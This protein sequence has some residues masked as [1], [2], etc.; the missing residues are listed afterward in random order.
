M[1]VHLGADHAAFEVK[2]ALAET[3]RAAGHDVVDHGP[4]SYDAMDDYPVFCLRAA[5]AVAADATGDAS[6]GSEVNGSESR[7]IVL[8][9]SGN[10]EQI[11]AN[12]VRGIRAALAWSSETARLAREHNDANVVGIGARMHSEDEVVEIVTT[13]LQTPYS[14]EDRHDRRIGMITDYETTGRLP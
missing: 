7:G 2:N 4:F 8:G 11:V 5:T 1:R 14:A 3:L 6:H 12:K 10:G 13:F 9:G